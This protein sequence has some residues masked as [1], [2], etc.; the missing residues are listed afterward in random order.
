MCRS[1]LQKTSECFN[2]TH[3]C[4]IKEMIS[5]RFVW[6]V[7]GL[8][9][10]FIWDVYSDV[11]QLHF[12]ILYIV[13]VLGACP[14]IRRISYSFKNRSVCQSPRPFS[15]LGEDLVCLPVL[16]KIKK[17]KKKSLPRNDYISLGFSIDKLLDR[18]RND[19]ERTHPQHFYKGV[20]QI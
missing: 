6:L 15:R 14:S 11:L 9:H 2:L 17:K 19:K 7:N 10:V 20:P 16:K 1:S 18:Q 12:S 8:F 13:S 4:L 3:M 5:Q